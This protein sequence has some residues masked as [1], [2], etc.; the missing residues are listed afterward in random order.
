MQQKGIMDP[1]IAALTL[2]VSF[3]HG[4]KE[5]FKRVAAGPKDV[6]SRVKSRPR[7]ENGPYAF[8]LRNI[9][10][11]DGPVNATLAYV[12][13]PP[14]KSTDPFTMEEDEGDNDD[15]TRPAS[16]LTLTWKLSILFK[17]GRKFDGY[18]G[19][20]CQ[21]GLVRLLDLSSSPPPQVLESWSR[22]EERREGCFGWGEGASIRE[23]VRQLLGRGG[24]EPL[25]KE[26][27]VGK[28]LTYRSLNG[29]L[30]W[31]IDRMGH[32]WAD[33]LSSVNRTIIAHA[34]EGAREN[35]IPVGSNPNDVV[36][37]PQIASK[38]VVLTSLIPAALAL[39]PCNP[40]FLMAR[41]A[42][43]Q[44][45]QLFFNG[46]YKC[47]LWRG[48][49]ERGMGVNAHWATEMIWTPWGGGKRKDEFDVPEECGY[50]K[51]KVDATEN[52]RDEL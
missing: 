22:E 33:I 1:V 27:A 21:S 16:S 38:D 34:D 31:G 42:L 17:N 20:R 37:E 44:A 13:T 46:T 23:G 8:E 48:S 29:R 9:P 19:A 50:V 12:Q 28:P 10:G 4:D 52:R 36:P 43:I 6:F 47:A 25:P 26:G 45:D 49:A 11:A 51:V 14:R 30:H 15:E 32:V 40:T 35:E 2:L 7:P 41:D 39:I 24:S 3:P 18:M 5:A